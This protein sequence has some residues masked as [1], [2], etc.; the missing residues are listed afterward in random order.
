MGFS[1]EKNEVQLSDYESHLRPK[2]LC[3][4]SLA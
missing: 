4:L 2:L 1:K 3:A